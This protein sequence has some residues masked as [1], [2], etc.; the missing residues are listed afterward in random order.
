MKSKVHKEGHDRL[1]ARLVAQARN[2]LRRQQL[3]SEFLSHTAI[4]TDAADSLQQLP[5]EELQQAAGITTDTLIGDFVETPTHLVPYP[6]NGPRYDLMT[7]E[8][9]ERVRTLSEALVKA[10]RKDSLLLPPEEREAYCR[11]QPRR[12]SK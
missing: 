7:P 4:E 5:L 11:E 9:R 10:I 2:R 8:Q 3:E 6:G 12:L 1:R